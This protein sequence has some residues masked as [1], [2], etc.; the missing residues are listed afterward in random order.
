MACKVMSMFL[1]LPLSVGEYM[2]VFYTIKCA[3]LYLKMHQNAF[4]GPLIE[5]QDTLGWIKGDG[6]NR[7]KDGKGVEEDGNGKICPLLFSLNKKVKKE[8]AGCQRWTPLWSP[9]YATNQFSF[10]LQSW[11]TF[12][13]S[14]YSGQYNLTRK[15]C[16]RKETARCSS[17][18]FPCKV[19]RQQSLQV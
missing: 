17:C 5:L 7:G 2:I 12:E 8:G 13:W 14:N 6:K 1:L 15:P 18:S 11:V 19:R 10:F 3:S 16:C 9:T 4:G